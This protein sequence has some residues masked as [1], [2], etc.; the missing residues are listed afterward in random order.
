MNLHPLTP[1]AENDTWAVY[2]GRW[3][4]GRKDVWTTT[5]A[6]DLEIEGDDRDSELVAR[7]WCGLIVRLST[8]AG[9]IEIA[10]RVSSRGFPPDPFCGVCGHEWRGRAKVSR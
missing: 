10:R 1:S 6:F 8:P 7:T 5:H 4:I 3:M 9:R 2:I